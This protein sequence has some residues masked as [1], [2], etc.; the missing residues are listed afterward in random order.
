MNK[1]IA[2]VIDTPEGELKMKEILHSSGV[3]TYEM[4][5]DRHDRHP[6]ASTAAPKRK[7]IVSELNI[8]SHPQKLRRAIE[9]KIRSAQVNYTIRR[10]VEEASVQFAQHQTDNDANTNLGEAEVLNV[11]EEAKRK[12]KADEE[13]AKLKDKAD[14]EEAKLKAKADEEAKRKLKAEA[15]EEAKRKLKA[16]ADEEEAKLKAKA[17]EEAKRKLK[18]K[19]DEE[20]A[21]R[22][23]KLKADEEEA[24][25][26]LKAK[27]DEEEAKRK[28]KAKAEEEEAKRK[29]KADEEE[30]KRKA[31]AKA[32]EE[33]AKRKAKADEEAKLKLKADEEEAKRKAKADAEA[34]AKLKAKADEEAKEANAE[35]ELNAT[36]AK[37]DAELERNND[38]KEVATSKSDHPSAG[39]KTRTRSDAS[40]LKQPP[41]T[42]RMIALQKANELAEEKETRPKSGRGRGRGRHTVKRGGRGRSGRVE[43]GGTPSKEDTPQ[44]EK[45]PAQQDTEPLQG[46]E[47]QTDERL[48]ENSSIENKDDQPISTSNLLYTLPDPDPDQNEPVDYE[49]TD[50]DERK[51]LETNDRL[52]ETEL[53]F[54]ILANEDD[55]FSG[56][57]IVPF[58]CLGEKTI[59][60]AETQKKSEYDEKKISEFQALRAKSTLLTNDTTNTDHIKQKQQQAKK[61]DNDKS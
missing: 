50:D 6:S 27:A 7:R 56:V 3:K 11:N 12:L 30:A 21:K 36:Q 46:V 13:E 34:E 38:S 45:S 32:D 39:K 4:N 52:P 17:D 54:P 15:D 60:A 48:P 28:A 49:N 29:L 8:R 22:K 20:E 1:S 5:V 19:A 42:R 37:T 31:K 35:D 25:R 58:D 24:K 61:D 23:A 53:Q 47:D 55:Q 44:R 14:E 33:E 9:E 51:T 26:K 18:A 10:A 57:P 41:V 43:D 2:S 16:K 59:D 40:S